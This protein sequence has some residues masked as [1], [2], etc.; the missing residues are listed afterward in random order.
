MGVK[1]QGFIFLSMFCAAYC[2]ISSA[3]AQTRK[4]SHATATSDTVLVDK[5]R[6]EGEKQSFTPRS[7]MKETVIIITKPDT[8][9]KY[10]P[11]YKDTVIIIKK[12]LSK[13]QIAARNKAGN[14]EEMKGNN[15]C[16]CVKMDIKA[17]L[18]LQYETYL[19]YDFIFKNN[20]KVDVWVSSKHFRF[21]PFTAAG[22]PVKVL[23]KL[24]FVNRYGQADFVKI[25]PGEVYTFTNSDDPFF[26]F[27]LK[28]GESYRFTFEHRNFGDKARMA[29]DKTY[30]CGQKRTQLIDIK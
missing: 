15:Y 27:D 22:N 21:T 1:I 29:P 16:D 14:I 30:L 19:S 20:C 3:E 25:T 11:T 12:G 24:S 9:K 4:R 7:D 5:A 26:E 17:P 13:A 8:S 23:H 28:K 10:Q 6:E 18:T 2:C